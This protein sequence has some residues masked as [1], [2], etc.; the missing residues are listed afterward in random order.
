[1]E[2]IVNRI[3]ISVLLALGV[4][5]AF[6]Q[7]GTVTTTDEKGKVESTSAAQTAAEK[8]ADS[9]CLRE[10]GSHLRAI[11]KDHSEHAVE[12][13]DALRHLDPSIH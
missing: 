1:L 4:G 2:K 8:S 13:A 6:A 5:S 7:P 9:F 3:L 10:T 12:C 11:K